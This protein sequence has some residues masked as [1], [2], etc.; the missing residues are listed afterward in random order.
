MNEKYV[1]MILNGFTC[2][3]KSVESN[4]IKPCITQEAEAN[5]SAVALLSR[6]IFVL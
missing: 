2:W 1:L 6:Y 5:L 4:D 3:A